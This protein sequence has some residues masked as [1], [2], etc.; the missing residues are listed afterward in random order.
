[1]QKLAPDTKK[2]LAAEIDLG[3][4]RIADPELFGRNMLRLMEEGQK[5]MSGLLERITARYGS[6][7]GWVAQLPTADDTVERLRSG[8]VER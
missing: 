7:D 8:L 5:V 4:Y 1:M 2:P 3:A 6:L